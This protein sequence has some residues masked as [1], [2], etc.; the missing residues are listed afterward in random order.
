MF[1]VKNISILGTFQW[2]FILLLLRFS[3]ADVFIFSWYRLNFWDSLDLKSGGSSRWWN[4]LWVGMSFGQVV[5]SFLAIP[6]TLN[7]SE[8]LYFRY[9]HNRNG[10]DLRF[11]KKRYTGSW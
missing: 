1:L 7:N 10:G 9:L 2:S 11:K 4:C 8:C 6:S 3:F 5:T